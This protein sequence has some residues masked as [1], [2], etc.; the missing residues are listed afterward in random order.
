MLNAERLAK[1]KERRAQ[2]SLAPAGLLVDEAALAEAL[3][4]RQVAAAAARRI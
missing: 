4:S 2:S 3:K 1:T